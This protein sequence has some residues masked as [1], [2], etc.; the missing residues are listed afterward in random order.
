MTSHEGKKG[1]E[2]VSN[3]THVRNCAAAIDSIISKLSRAKTF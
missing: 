1:M 2:S 3:L